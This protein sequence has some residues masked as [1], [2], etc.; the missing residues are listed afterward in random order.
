MFHHLYTI[1]FSQQHRF[2]KSIVKILTL[3][4]YYEN[5][6]ISEDEDNRDGRKYDL[7]SKS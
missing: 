4:N 3:K 7:A 6:Q 5:I 2:F 1:M